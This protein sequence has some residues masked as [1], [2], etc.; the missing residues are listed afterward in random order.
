MSSEL[1]GGSIVPDKFTCSWYCLNNFTQ[2]A[3]EHRQRQ[4]EEL[5]S[6][7][8]RDPCASVSA[9]G[10]VSISASH[11]EREMWEI[12]IEFLHN[13]PQTH[14]GR[15]GPRAE[16]NEPTE[17]IVKYQLRCGVK[18][19]SKVLGCR[20]RYHWLRGGQKSLNHFWTGLWVVER[21]Q[22]QCLPPMYVSGLS[23]IC[24]E[25]PQGSRYAEIG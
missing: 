17:T 4:M 12:E 20:F 2:L 18:M 7:Q 8:R 5:R 19:E 9:L 24:A 15:E 3:V 1:F 11:V 21:S 25:P 22:C 13:L 6:A 16:E 23:C 14:E 10:S